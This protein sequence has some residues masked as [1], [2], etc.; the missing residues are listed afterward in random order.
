MVFLQ[1]VKPV[2]FLMKLKMEM[3]KGLLFPEIMECKNSIFKWKI[4]A[5]K[6]VNAMEST[7]MI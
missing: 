2:I 6:N 5:F 1:A 4:K 3:V 7:I